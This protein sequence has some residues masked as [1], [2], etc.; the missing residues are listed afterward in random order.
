MEARA[1]DRLYIPAGALSL[2]FCEDGTLKSSVHAAIDPWLPDRGK[3]V[4]VTPDQVDEIEE[5]GFPLHTICS[6]EPITACQISDPIKKVLYMAGMERRR[7]IAVIDNSSVVGTI[8]LDHARGLVGDDGK[9]VIGD[10]YEPNTG[11]SVLSGDSP[12]MDYILSA[13]IHPYRIVDLGDGRCGNVDVFC[14]QKLPART[15]LQLQFSHLELRIADFL[16]QWEPS[17]SNLVGNIEAKEFAGFG[18]FA[19]G[20]E[21]RIDTFTFGKLL[22][23]ARDH[24]SN[25]GLSTSE[26][27]ALNKFRNHVAHGPRW[28]ITRQGDVNCLVRCVKRVREL[29]KHLVTL[30]IS[31][32]EAK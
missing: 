6:D 16:C 7:Y 32:E 28:Y 18:E 4:G 22:Q 23:G 2:E 30:S 20:P 26:V 10:H 21:R 25:L 12:L 13:D 11:T 5:K 17:Y 9:I 29:I 19:G 24:C 1:G 15:L 3:A 14:L 27:E 31:L 8:N